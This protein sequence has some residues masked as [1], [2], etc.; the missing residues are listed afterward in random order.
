MN[1]KVYKIIQ[2]EIILRNIKGH[3]K[4]WNN[5]CFKDYESI[6]R[7]RPINIVPRYIS[8]SKPYS[9]EP[10]ESVINIKDSY[11]L[12]YGKYDKLLE[13]DINNKSAQWAYGYLNDN[14]S[15][16][17]YLIET[18]CI[19]ENKDIWRSLCDSGGISD[20][21][22]K[23]YNA[24]FFD[25]WFYELDLVIELDGNPWHKEDLIKAEKDKIRDKYCKLMYPWLRVERF[26]F[27]DL[28]R[29][30]DIKRFKEFIRD[31]G[32]FKKENINRDHIWEFNY[33]DKVTKSF[34]N[35]HHRVID[36]LEII[37]N[38]NNLNSLFEITPEHFKKLGLESLYPGC[39]K[40]IKTWLFDECISKTIDTYEYRRKRRRR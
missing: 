39:R 7:G 3:Q 21:Y 37:I 28:T 33:L 12:V 1:E 29:P 34:I 6:D 11:T 26:D 31:L 9:W 38:H 40:F 23:N 25:L 36:V 22:F 17:K 10:L 30:K 13:E 32:V 15:E 16:F 14:F 20:A 4:G 2:D 19:I 5:I 35:Y 8:Y 24:I 27:N 18:P